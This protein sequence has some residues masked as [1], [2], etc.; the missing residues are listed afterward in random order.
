M[1]AAYKKA[2]P[3]QEECDKAKVFMICQGSPH[4]IKMHAIKEGRGR[5]LH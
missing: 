3:S 4:S 5:T 2:K 1:Q